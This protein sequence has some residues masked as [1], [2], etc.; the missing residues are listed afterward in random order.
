[1]L[2]A[3]STTRHSHVADFIINPSCGINSTQYEARLYYGFFTAK[4][5]RLFAYM[6]ENLPVGTRYR[7][8]RYK[9]FIR[10]GK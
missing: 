3:I 2:N 5:I 10:D 4:L 6:N 8:R 7:T 9:P 1:M